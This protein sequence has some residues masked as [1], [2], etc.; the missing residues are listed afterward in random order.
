MYPVGM[1]ITR[2]DDDHLAHL[3]RDPLTV[4]GALIRTLKRNHDLKMRMQ[5]FRIKIGSPGNDEVEAREFN[6]HARAGVEDP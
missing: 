5:M 3:R 1:P 6:A 4:D 2:L